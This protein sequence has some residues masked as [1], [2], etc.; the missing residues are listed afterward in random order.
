MVNGVWGT[1]KMSLSS[2]FFFFW[3]FSC[4]PFPF[5]LRSSNKLQ[6]QIIKIIINAAHACISLCVCAYVFE[7][8]LLWH[9]HKKKPTKQEN[10]LKETNLVGESE[11]A[12][13]LKNI[14]KKK[15]HCRHIKCDLIPP[16]HTNT[17][18]NKAQ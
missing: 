13:F 17:K 12:I 1:L 15:Y 2:H 6:L 8:L 18:K 9:G 11:R 4:F 10:P 14:K 7:A 16:T 3:V 5:P